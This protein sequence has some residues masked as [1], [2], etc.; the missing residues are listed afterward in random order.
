MTAGLAA[1]AIAAPQYLGSPATT[2]D[3]DAVRAA[4]ELDT[5]QAQAASRSGSRGATPEA[6]SSPT[7]TTAAEPTPTAT[8]TPDAGTGTGDDTAAGSGTGAGSGAGSA[9]QPAPQ[10]ATT[11]PV[12]A[13][14]PAATAPQPADVE[15]VTL[16]N[17][18]RR[19]A[20]LGDLAVSACA[21]EQALARASLLVAEGRFEHDP[22]EPIL[23][24]CGGRTVGENLA[25]GY[26]TAQATV[27]AWLASPGHRAN[28]LSPNFTSIGVACV[29]GPRG[30]LCAQVFLG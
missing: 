19:A 5:R 29:D 3:S 28:L 15:I 7:V 9:G 18:A 22:L 16:G 23:A 20:G 8:P 12:P 11:D 2:R 17:A 24:A 30:P 4:A 6:S 14:A 13:P 26:P 25:V 27:D 1:A 10:P 21:Q